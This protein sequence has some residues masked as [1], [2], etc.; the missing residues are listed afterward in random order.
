MQKKT[1]P[2]QPSLFEGLAEMLNPKEPLYRLADKIPWDTL[3]EEFAKY[4]INFGRPAKPTRLMISLLILKRIYDKGDETVVAAWV[5]NPYWQYFSGM[6]QFQW[7]VP[8]EPSDL[9]HFRKRI[10][11]EGLERIFQVSID[12]Q[13]PKAVQEKEVVVDTTVQEKN[14]TFPTDTKLYRKIA[15]HCLKIAEQEGVALRRSYRRTIPKLLFAQ[16][17]RNHPCGHK[18]ANKATAKLK[19]IAGRLVRE[20]DRKLS[21][22]G[23]AVRREQLNL[24]KR[25]LEQKRSDKNKVYSLHEPHVYCV[26]KGKTHKKYE[27]GSKASFAMTKA[28]GVIVGALNHEKNLYDGKTLPEVLKEIAVRTGCDPVAVIVDQGYR[29]RKKIGDTQI[30]SADGFKKKLTPYQRRKLK[31]QLRR[32]AAIE[33]VIGHLKSDFRLA[34]NYLKG[35]I[36]DQMNV[37]LAATAYNLAKWMRESISVFLRMLKF[38]SNW[39]PKVVFAN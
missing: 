37:L 31:K 27:F 38:C 12:I 1:I 23:L 24:Y 10:G 29:G 25:A 14:I 16:R 3:E 34:R 32:R 22:E 6:D 15:E 19:T 35:A 28:G 4:Y 18:K 36:G 13:N 26:S 5:Q 21:K 11:P 7:Q 8:C 30:V 20:L 17:G 9:V 39:S 2:N 33:P